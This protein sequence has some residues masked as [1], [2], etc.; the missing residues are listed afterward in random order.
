MREKARAG[1]EEVRNMWEGQCK[2]EEGKWL[3]SSS[4]GSHVLGAGVQSKSPGQT[5]CKDKKHN[6]NTLVFFPSIF[7]LYLETDVNGCLS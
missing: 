2:V 7:H 4:A 5:R 6:R 3:L 1:S